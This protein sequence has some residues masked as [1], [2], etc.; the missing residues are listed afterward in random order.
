MS[1]G[2]TKSPGEILTEMK[3]EVLD[4][5]STRVAMLHSEIQENIRSL[6][7]AA[8]MLIVGLVLLGTAWLLL[9]GFLVAAIARAFE[10]NPWAY[11]FSFGIACVAYL[12]MG[13]TAAAAA[14]KRI[15][16]KGL[17]PWR[18]IHVLQQDKAWLEAEGKAQS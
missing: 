18:T 13:G 2:Y 14:W 12:V 6:K 9:T 1:N 4:F 10:P 3:S 5:V 8:P 16:G 7:L 11:S 15:A 17:T